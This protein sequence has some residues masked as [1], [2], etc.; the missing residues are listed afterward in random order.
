MDTTRKG[1][2]LKADPISAAFRDEVKKDLEACSS[3]PKL[4]GIL[5]TSSA[6]SN[7]YAEFTRKQ[8]EEL[9]FEFV[10][11][12]TGAALSSDLA[13]GEGVEEAIIDANEDD[14]V[15]G[16]MVSGTHNKL[17]PGSDMSSCRSRSI[18]QYLG[19]SR[20]VISQGQL[21]SETEDYLHRI[22]I[23]TCSR[24]VHIH[25]NPLKFT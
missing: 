7:N 12:K 15:H 2:L 22:R 24:C 10:L 3:R 16:I 9:G 18:T 21:T 11:K 8:C 19:C 14:S 25:S 23:T 6:P 1:L 17:D 13:A 4:V 20:L 5:A